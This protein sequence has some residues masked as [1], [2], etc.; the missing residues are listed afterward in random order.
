MYCMDSAVCT[1]RYLTE[2][3]RVHRLSKTE[4]QNGHYSATDDGRCRG[5]RRHEAAEITDTP[6]YTVRRTP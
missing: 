3:S 6:K 1:R 5:E 2:S 4:E